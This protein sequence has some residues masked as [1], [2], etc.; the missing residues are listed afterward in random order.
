MAVLMVKDQTYY[1]RMSTLYN[2]MNQMEVVNTDLVSSV[3]KILTDTGICTILSTPHLLG[4]LQRI[5]STF[6]L[7]GPSP[8]ARGSC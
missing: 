3:D 5:I 2:C 4:N 7:V 8:T 6:K 1:S